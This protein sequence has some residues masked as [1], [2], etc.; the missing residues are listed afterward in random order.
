M[1]RGLDTNVLIYAHLPSFPEHAGVRRFLLDELATPGRKLVLTPS[2]LHEF[3]HVVTDGRRFDVPVSMA[4]AI[5][6]ARM[7]TRRANVD[8]VGATEESLLLA[9]DLIERHS[10]GRKRVA[11]TLLA[12]TLLHHGVRQIVSCDPDDF[13]VFDNLEVIDPRRGR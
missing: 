8:C 13:A 4:E 3:V 11:D 5:A 6:V 9:F 2:V 12:A 1:K 10:L 7:W